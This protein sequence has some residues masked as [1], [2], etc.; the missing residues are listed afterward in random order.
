MVRITGGF[1]AACAV[2]MLAALPASAE[3]IKCRLKY[4]L[5]GWS[6]FYEHSTGTGR[7]S[8]SDGQAANVN[9]VTHGGGATFGTHRVI[10][11]RGV[12]SAVHDIEELY[13]AYAEAVAHAGAGDSADAR[14]MM[15]RTVSLALAGT[16]QGLNLGLSLGSFSIRPM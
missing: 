10:G 3:M 2:L 9:I 4:D 12:F 11:G 13:G 14:A 7:V 8:C 1:A 15:K 16:G 6:V 5:K